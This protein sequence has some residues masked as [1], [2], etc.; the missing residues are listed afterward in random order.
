[1]KTVEEVDLQVRELSRGGNPA[2]RGV[3][4]ANKYIQI[5][6]FHSFWWFLDFWRFPLDQYKKAIEWL[7][8]FLRIRDRDPEAL[9]LIGQCHLNESNPVKGLEYLKK[10]LEARPKQPQVALKV[11][12]LLICQVI[13]IFWHDFLLKHHN[14]SPKLKT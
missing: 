11:A 1:M 9:H 7:E 8:Q 14:S 3:L 10:S 13:M 5:R 6:K 4:F 2:S 12:E